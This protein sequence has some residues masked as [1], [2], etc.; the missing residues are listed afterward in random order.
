MVHTE[1]TPEVAEQYK[2]AAEMWGSVRREFLHALGQ[3]DPSP[4]SAQSKK[5]GGHLWRVFWAAHQRFFR[6]MCMAA[7]V[8]AC[9]AWPL[10]LRAR[11]GRGTAAPACSALAGW[12]GQGSK[13][14][15][16]CS[17]Q[18]ALTGGPPY[19]CALGLRQAARRCLGW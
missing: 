6:H 9:L 2:L 13:A 19:G 11:P 5:R 3:G 17:S 10:P 8:R 12:A 4:D 18:P 1:L 14:R 7:K 15:A 16:S